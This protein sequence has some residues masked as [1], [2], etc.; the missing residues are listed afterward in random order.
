[1]FLK[2]LKVKSI[3]VVSYFSACQ[4]STFVFSLPFTQKY[5]LDVTVMNSCHELLSLAAQR[6]DPNLLLS[7]NFSFTGVEH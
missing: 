1:M 2:H 6:T 4:A 5:Q 7:W 3:S